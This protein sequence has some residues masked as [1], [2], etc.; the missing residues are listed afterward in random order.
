MAKRAKERKRRKRRYHKISDNQKHWHMWGSISAFM[1]MRKD[2]KLTKYPVRLRDFEAVG[3]TWHFIPG[4]GAFRARDDSRSLTFTLQ[5]E[6]WDETHYSE[7]VWTLTVEGRDKLEGLNAR[8]SRGQQ[9]FGSLHSAFDLIVDY[10]DAAWDTRGMRD[11][12]TLIRDHMDA[13]FTRR[14]AWVERIRDMS[15]GKYPLEL[16]R[17]RARVAEGDSE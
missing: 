8:H 11:R 13:L 16:E 12:V 5:T 14:R 3:L 6:R 9:P 7:D 17:E 15:D 4:V 2:S 10:R 1:Q